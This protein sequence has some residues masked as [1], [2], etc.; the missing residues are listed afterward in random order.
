MVNGIPGLKREFVILLHIKYSLNYSSYI[1][2]WSTIPMD[3]GP[4]WK[5][6]SGRT[7]LTAEKHYLKAVFNYSNYSCVPN[8]RQITRSNLA[9]RYI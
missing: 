4:G 5:T 3:L 6:H 8:H 2:I 9:S 1:Y 7:G